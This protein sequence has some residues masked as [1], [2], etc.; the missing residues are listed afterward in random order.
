MNQQLTRPALRYF[1]GK[2]KLGKWII[3]HFPN[4]DS[5]IEPFGGAASVL[6]QK[7]RSRLETYNDLDSNVVNFFR[8][9]RDRKD[10]LAHQ[11]NYTPYSREEYNLSTVATGDSLEDARRFFVACWMAIGHSGATGCRFQKSLKGRDTPPDKE[12]H[13]L[14]TGGHIDR[15]AS[16]F[17]GVQIESDSYEGVIDRYDN[18][19]ALFYVDPPYPKST[20]TGNRYLCEL[21]TDNEHIGLADKLTAVKGMVVLSGY[22]CELYQELYADWTHVTKRTLSNSGKSSIESLWLSPNISSELSIVAKQDHNDYSNLF[23]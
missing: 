4:H 7:P 18:K 23:T 11:L 22:D 9:L 13:E 16:R 21:Q 5:Y 14:I 1:G 17:H 10:E 19:K 15:V 12:F 2:W 6:L 20:R 3:S 8:V